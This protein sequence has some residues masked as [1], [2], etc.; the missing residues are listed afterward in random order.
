MPDIETPESLAKLY[1]IGEKPA[2]P[3]AGPDGGGG[4]P[5]APTAEDLVKHYGI[6][7]RPF[8]TTPA[9]APQIPDIKDRP[10][11]NLPPEEE[12]KFQ[13][14]VKGTSWHKEFTE[15]HGEPDLNDPSYDLRRA[16][17]AG[18]IPKLASDKTFHWADSEPGTGEELKSV[19]HPT[20]WMEPFMKQYPGANPEDEIDPRVKAY[21][22][23]WQA[24]YPSL[25]QAP[26]GQEGPSA[27]GRLLP[28]GAPG[29]VPGGPQEGA[30]PYAQT[31]GEPFA[32]VRRFAVGFDRP[33]VEALHGLV[34]G[35]EKTINWAFGQSPDWTWQNS[36]EG[37]LGQMTGWLLKNLPENEGPRADEPISKWSANLAGNLASF[38]VLPKIF[39]LAGAELPMAGARS[40]FGKGISAADRIT[41]IGQSLATNLLNFGIVDVSRAIGAGGG[42][43]EAREALSHSMSTAA[44]FTVAG[45]LPFFKVV[46]NPWLAKALESTATGGAF[47][48]SS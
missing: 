13:N 20:A 47:A 27:L 38:M 14:W 46:R 16:W 22:E 35:T 42:L 15:K 2:G 40:I 7:T 4:L 6:G 32:K 31:Y 33:V 28:P 41:A 44:L 18:V 25:G 5:S 1:G 10:L 26:A 24:K 30:D 11:L 12:Q 3:S 43:R 37:A 8:N 23:A 34:S 36:P 9:E 48:G 39:K 29:K 21:R 19:H 45:A 17:K